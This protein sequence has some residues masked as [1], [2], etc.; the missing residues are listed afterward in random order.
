MTL[1]PIGIGEFPIELMMREV[2]VPIVAGFQVPW[3]KVETEEFGPIDLTTGAGVGSPYG[4]LTMGKAGARRY[5]I[6][7]A[8]DL[9]NAITNA[10]R[11]HDTA[12][13]EAAHTEENGG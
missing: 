1:D 8:N 12:A 4:I 10:V 6:F 9:L 5:F 11:S 7:N 13:P 2:E 3:G